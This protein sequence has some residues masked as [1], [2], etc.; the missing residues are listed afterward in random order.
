[1]AN[2]LYHYKF[3]NNV[4]FTKDIA[5][6]FADQC[7]SRLTSDVQYICDAVQALGT[8]KMTTFHFR[9]VYFTSY[10]EADVS[11][12]FAR[13]SRSDL[14]LRSCLY[15]SS[16]SSY[17]RSN[18]PRCIRSSTTSLNDYCRQMRTLCLFGS[19]L[20]SVWLCYAGGGS[21]ISNDIDGLLT[22]FSRSWHLKSNLLMDKVTTEH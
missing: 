1:L 21:D 18:F 9:E 12:H 14:P 16:I 10:D 22:R 11:K 2:K 8:T 13:Q 6:S 7:K 17:R 5:K 15:D 20:Y 4:D 19:Y 3:T